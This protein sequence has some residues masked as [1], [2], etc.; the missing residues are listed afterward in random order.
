M[1]AR[2]LLIQLG[3][4]TIQHNYR[5]QNRMTDELVKEGAWSNIDNQC[6]RWTVLLLFALKHLEA[7]KLLVYTVRRFQIVD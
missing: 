6:V 4:L 2:E 1:I 5:E 3:N 7:Q